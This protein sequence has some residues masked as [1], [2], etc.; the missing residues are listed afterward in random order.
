M[1]GYTIF[2]LLIILYKHVTINYNYNKQQN[3]KNEIV[4]VNKSTTSSACF[5]TELY[6]SILIDRKV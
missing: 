6:N 2:Y 1:L 3:M 5:L 4:N